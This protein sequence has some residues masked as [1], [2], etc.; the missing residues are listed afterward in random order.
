MKII[1]TFFI[2]IVF[3]YCNAQSIVGHLEVFTHL[4]SKNIA[5]RKV[6]V[7]QSSV[8]N[9]APCNVIY[10]HDGQMLFDTTYTW[11]HKEWRADE[12]ADSLIKAGAVPNFIIVGIESI[13]DYRYTDLM[14]QKCFNKL[15]LATKLKLLKNQ[16]AAPNADNYLK[17]IVHTVKPFIDKKYNTIKNA[18]ATY[19]GGSSMG[20]LNSWYALSEYP[21]VFG[22]AMCMS[23]HWPGSKPTENGD[24]IFNTFYNY[25]LTKKNIIANKKKYFDWGNKTLDAYYSNYQSKITALLSP[26]NNESNWIKTVY[27]ENAAHDENAWAA[28]LAGAFM[29]VL[30]K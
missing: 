13:N 21:K 6:F 17:Y 26:K 30:K 15:P 23:T 27:D 4:K 29:Y 5:A 20:G 14:P 11:N 9:N 3:K 7:W 10:M 12:T 25:L 1:L 28:R 22:G 16:K 2:A 8:N 19:V 24:T 18:N